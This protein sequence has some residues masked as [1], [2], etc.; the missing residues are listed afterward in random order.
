Y[1]A[2]KALATPADLAYYESA[3]TQF[4]GGNSVN[5]ALYAN[6][7]RRM[8]ADKRGRTVWV[9]NWAG[10]NIAE[11]D[12][13]TLRGTYHKLPVSGQPYKT[14]VDAQHNVWASVPLADSLVKY[15][16][17]ARGWTV[18]PFATHGCG[19][20]HVWADKARGEVWVP[21]DQASKVERFQFRTPEEIRSQ[22]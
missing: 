10:M 12:I 14:D 3:G 11:I 16:P 21:C 9:P 6:A 1:A 20:R 7:P 13:R 2:R 19:P 22:K 17:N 4:W 8:S 5:P 15:D 18:Y